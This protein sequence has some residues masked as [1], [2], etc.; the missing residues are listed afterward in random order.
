MIEEKRLRLNDE[1]TQ[2]Y[3]ISFNSSSEDQ[4]LPTAENYE[5]NDVPFADIDE[6][7]KTTQTETIKFAEMT[8]QTDLRRPKCYNACSQTEELDYMYTSNARLVTDFNEDYF[9]NS[10]DKVKFY[11]GLPCYGVLNYVYELLAPSV[12]RRSQTLSKFQELVMVLM[13]LRLDVP[14]QDL[15]YRFGDI[16]VPTVSRTFRTWLMV[17]DTRLSPYVHWRGRESLIRTM[18]V[19]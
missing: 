16:S 4:S 8:T 10:D 15:A 6:N 2:V 3:D 13:K 18:P 11:T 12:S 1:G 19:L 14:L 17:M 9:R 5:V 7:D